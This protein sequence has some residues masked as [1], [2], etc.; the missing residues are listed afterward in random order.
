MT[1]GGCG[2]N[3]D[4]AR[5]GTA[6]AAAAMRQAAAAVPAMYGC[7]SCDGDCG[8]YCDGGCDVD[9]G[10]SVRLLPHQCGPQWTMFGDF[11]Y[12]Q[13][14][15]VDVAHAQQQDGIGGAGTV[16]FGEIGYDRPGFQSR[17]PRRRL[18]WPADRARV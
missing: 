18:A 7:G 16:P 9:C 8:S 11:L 4:A 3:G 14:T 1:A 2:P 12:L 15:D 5:M 17:L 6:V 10:V 13:V